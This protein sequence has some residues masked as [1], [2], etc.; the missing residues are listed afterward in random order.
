[1]P[2]PRSWSPQARTLFASLVAAAGEWSH[3][4]DLSKRT[5]LKSGTLYPLLM[6]L[7]DQRLLDAQWQKPQQAG[8][9]ARHVYRLTT[10]GLGLARQIVARERTVSD[11]RARRRLKS[12]T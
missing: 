4:Y 8:R 9:P 2:R 1:M 10:R 7:A 3:G 12:A 11:R 6:R 5:G